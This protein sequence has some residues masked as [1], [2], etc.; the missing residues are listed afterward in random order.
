MMHAPFVWLLH[1]WWLVLPGACNIFTSG[2]K[3]G[4]SYASSTYADWLYSCVFVWN[5]HLTLNKL[6]VEVS[7]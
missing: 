3:R 2:L 7:T 1:L 5:I 6:P 4:A